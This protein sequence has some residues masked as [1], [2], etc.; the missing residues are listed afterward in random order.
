MTIA[1][2]FP[3]VDSTRRHFLSQA[4]GVAA[5]GAVV[6]SG[7]LP[8]RLAMASPT[9]PLAPA[10]A[11]PVSADPIFAAIEAHK[12]A[13]V[14]MGSQLSVHSE[15]GRLLPREK[16]ES[17]VD[18]F[19]EKIVATDDPRWID[20]GR[21]VIR[22]FET[23]TNAACALIAVRPTTIAGVLALL[24]YANAA[25]VDGETWPGELESD[26]GD[27][28]RSWHYFLIE[29]LAEVLPGMVTS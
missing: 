24:H 2:P 11:S 23:E 14:A 22:S 12:A 3:P 1:R 26:D 5:S 17:S 6:A 4:A 13:V 16:R 18:A 27:K 21:A 20:S 9:S 19:E 8:P 29:A 25:D 7:A 15:L 28:T 10:K